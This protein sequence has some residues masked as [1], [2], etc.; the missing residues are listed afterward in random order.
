MVDSGDGDLVWSLDVDTW[1]GT[2][3]C[4]RLRF[5]DQRLLVVGAAT[6]TAMVQPLTIV[7]T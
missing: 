1:L 5:G 3:M 4:D 7:A 2:A 6:R